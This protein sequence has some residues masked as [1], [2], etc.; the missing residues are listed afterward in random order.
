MKKHGKFVFAV[1]L[2]LAIV[3]LF[4]ACNGSGKKPSQTTA[5]G[6][7]GSDIATQAATTEPSTDAP[8]YSSN[9]KLIALTFDDGPRKST[10][11]RILDIL[12]K[13]NSS[14]TFFLV[15]YN[16]DKNKETIKRAYDLGCEIANHSNEHKN[17]TKCTSGEIRNQ[18]DKPNELIKSIT[19]EYP[20]LFR[21]PGGNFQ[22][23]EN[24]IGMPLIQWSIDTEDWRYKDAAHEDRTAE[25]RD[26]DL[27]KIAD[28]VIENAEKGDIV[29]MHD[30]Y[31]FTADLCELVIPGL[32][33]KGFRLV[34]VSEMY[35]AYGKTLDDGKVYLNVEF[36]AAEDNTRVVTAGNY[37]VKTKG[38]VLNIRTEP[39]YDSQT[40]AKIPNGTQISVLKSVPGWAYVVY[41]SAE[42]WV[43][44]AYLSEQ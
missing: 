11:N 6:E 23:V 34:T 21:A 40:V 7:G 19:G 42:G 2:L 39:D 1:S 41:N 13:N 29:L 15:G 27:K 16:I 30:I 9:E 18:V 25:E 35:K 31:D 8:K 37:V 28:R 44:T 43:N 22:G 20:A 14:A 5:G 26:A 17:L 4:G 3:M 12:E 36:N 32:V 10:T 24:D 38:S 33:E